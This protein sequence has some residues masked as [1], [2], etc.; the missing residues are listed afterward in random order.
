LD[1]QRCVVS[2]PFDVLDFYTARSLKPSH[3]D[4]G[5]ASMNQKV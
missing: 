1:I 5:V 4:L 3:S 2:F